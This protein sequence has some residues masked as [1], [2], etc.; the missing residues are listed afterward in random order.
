MKGILTFLLAAD[1]CM[2]TAFAQTPSPFV[3]RWDFNTGN[4]SA[5]WLGVTE[6]GG[7]VEV[8]FQPTG[9]NVRQLKSFKLDGTHL[10][11]NIDPPTQKNPALIWELDATYGKLTGLQKRGANELALIGARAPELKR[12]PP[13]AWTTPEPLFNGKDL[14]GWEPSNPAQS[15]WIVEN[16]DPVNQTRGANLIG[17]RTF[18][19][20]KLHIEFN[21]PDDANSGI[22]LRGRY[23]VQLE[24][25][26]LEENP[27]ERRIGS[28]FGRIAP[29]TPPVRKPGAWESFDITLIGRTVTIVHN[30]VLTIDHKEIEG[31]TGGALDANEGE[32]GPF[33]IQGDHTGGLRFRNITISVP[34][35]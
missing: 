7:N 4:R 20:L 10:T 1:V 9:G 23:E 32:P 35:R 19:D 15:H 24:Y 26:A 12:N 31:I 18:D 8:W 6:K 2:S 30:G 22:Y 29:T 21:C 25:E 11:L 16:G 17:T 14:T 5:N 33:Y 13:A 28:V 3:G 27:P 34:R